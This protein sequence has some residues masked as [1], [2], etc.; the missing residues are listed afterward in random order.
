MTY[1]RI[2]LNEIF[3]IRDADTSRKPKLFEFQCKNCGKHGEVDGRL[4][5]RKFC[6]DKCYKD[7]LQEQRNIKKILAVKNKFK[8]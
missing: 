2:N 8:L 5:W 3:T 6:H 1:I 7:Y 4:V